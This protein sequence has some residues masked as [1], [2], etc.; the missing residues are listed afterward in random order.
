[1][2]DPAR[3]YTQATRS[4]LVALSQG[5]C[6]EPECS[7]PLIVFDEG[8]PYTNFDIAHIRDAKPGNRY[9]ADMTDSER[10]NFRNLV[11]LCRVHHTKVDKTHP[12]HY[13][14]E[15]LEQWKREAAEGDLSEVDVAG[16]GIV[17]EELLRSAASTVRDSTSGDQLGDLFRQVERFLSRA[18]GCLSAVNAIH[19]ELDQE[20]SSLRPLRAVQDGRPIVLQPELPR[21]TVSAYQSRADSALRSGLAELDAERVLTSEAAAAV[22]GASGQ[23][24]V[25]Y[26]EWLGR[27]QV[28][29]IRA[30]G[31][32][33]RDRYQAAVD[34]LG[35]SRDALAQVARREDR[36]QI[37]EPPAELP[38][39]EPS[40]SE[41]ATL[42]IEDLAERARAA[43]SHPEVG[44]E[45]LADLWDAGK[46]ASKSR[47]IGPLGSD[48]FETCG[49]WLAHFLKVLPD[50]DVEASLLQIQRL[51]QFEYRLHSVKQLYHAFDG[52]S[53]SQKTIAA[54]G[55]NMIEAEANSTESGL[56]SH[57]YAGD[58]VRIAIWTWEWW[59][60]APTGP[61]TDLLRSLE[62][63]GPCALLRTF[64][65]HATINGAPRLT[66]Y[67][68][69]QAVPEDP[70]PLV[71]DELL[72][73]IGK[74]YPDTKPATT[75]PP[76]GD[77][78]DPC[79]NL[80]GEYLLIAAASA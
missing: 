5:T 72:D 1:M 57:G 13:S 67:G 46:I 64:A 24:L 29:L 2:T 23:N 40:T 3:K 35:R 50:S 61:K 25:D 31:E 43:R 66:F 8:D 6:Y 36:P 39:P 34:E 51:T 44:K 63:A 76:G 41:L 70:L 65:N 68:G 52:E 7:R 18:H 38:Q 53:D 12:E 58:A 75:M 71:R 77:E 30:L 16:D 60:E 26:S 69:L 10:A 62:A 78:E 28:D 48:P 17:L 27:A 19:E 20:R 4:A 80:V 42:A 59:A 79:V 21:A 32:W 22:A 9:V 55:L 33:D 54:A 45:V 73:A 15:M 47:R 49:F 11:L 74:H 56:L 37:P 14:I